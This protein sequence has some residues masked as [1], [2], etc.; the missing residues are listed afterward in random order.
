MNLTDP[1]FN[2]EKCV[3]DVQH[4]NSESFEQLYQQTGASLG[5]L[6]RSLE[7]DPTLA[8]DLLQETFE[9]IWAKIG[10]LREAATFWGW[11]RRIAVNLTLRRQQQARRRGWR[12]WVPLWMQPDLPAPEPA[13]GISERLDLEAALDKLP[14]SD[15]ALLI[16]REYHHL[17]YDELAITFSVPIGTIKSRLHS[18]RKKMLDLLQEKEVPLY[19][20]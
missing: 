12:A 7:R 17:T 13:H 16:L 6:I 9:L 2:L 5:R 3:Q 15:R 4:G 19:V 20:R 11:A 18:S 14:A 10:S 1:E 8:E